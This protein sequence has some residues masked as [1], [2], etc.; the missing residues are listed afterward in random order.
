MLQRDTVC[1]VPLTIREAPLVLIVSLRHV[2]LEYAEA[3]STILQT[4]HRLLFSCM[5]PLTV[6][7]S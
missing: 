5:S 2:H 7:T 3:S 4:S 1:E 6:R